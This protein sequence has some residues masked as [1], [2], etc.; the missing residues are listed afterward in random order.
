LVGQIRGNIPR[1]VRKGWLCQIR[2]GYSFAI[3]ALLFKRKGV[4]LGQKSG[5][6]DNIVLV[7]WGV[8]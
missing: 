5:K 8:G 4:R 1:R 2:L 3:N 6:H 7:N